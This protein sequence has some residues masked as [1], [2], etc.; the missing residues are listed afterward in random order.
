MSVDVDKRSNSLIVSAPDVVVAEVER[1]VEGLESAASDTERSYRVLPIEN[2][3]P[4]DVR[5]ALE[6]LLN[7]QMKNSRGGAP[8]RPTPNRRAR[9]P[10]TRAPRSTSDASAVAPGLAG[11]SMPAAPARAAGT[12][13]STIRPT[14]GGARVT[15]AG[16][17]R[18]SVRLVG[19]FEEDDGEIVAAGFQ[20]DA[21]AA[22]AAD[23]R[24]GPLGGDVEITVL[25]DIGYLLLIGNDRDLETLAEIVREIEKAAK[26]RELTF[27][28]FPLSH[29]KA[30]ALA[31]LLN[32]LY[33]RLLDSRGQLTRVQAQATVIPLAKPNALLLVAGKDEIGELAELARKFDAPVAARGEYR[34]FRLRHVRAALLVQT[35]ESFYEGRG[36][37]GEMAQEVVVQP[38]D[39]S[40]SI[41][42]YA[43]PNDMAEIAGLVRELDTAQTARVNELR[44]FY[45]RHT[46]ATELA[47]VLEQAIAGRVGGAAAPA[48]G[49]SAARSLPALSF[50]DPDNPDRTIDSGILENVSIT[51]NRR[52]N[53]ILVAAPRQSLGVIESLIRQLDVLPEAVAEIKVFTLVNSDAATLLQTLRTLFVQLRNQQGEV[54]LASSA[55]GDGSNPLIEL[56]FSIDER[57][58]SIL[59]S[60]SREQLEVVEAI[61]LRLDASDIEERRTDVY[62]LKNAPA[63]DVAPALTELLSQ[64][65]QLAG[66]Q[67]G[68]SVQQQLEREIIVVPE[69]IS[70]SLLI[71]ASPRYYDRVTALIEKLDDLPPQVVIQVLLAQVQLDG[72]AELGVELGL[73]DG[74]LFDR[75]NFNST[76]V[77]RTG[78]YFNDGSTPGFNFNTGGPLGNNI[79]TTNPSAI[80][81]QGLSNFAVGRANDT[82]G[83][84]GLVLSASSES[85]SILI[86]ALA[87][88]RRLE[89]LSRPQIMTL[90]NQQASILVGAEVPRITGSNLVQGAGVSQNVEYVPSGIILEVTPKINPDGTIVMQVSP[91]IS[92]LAPANDPDQTVTISPGVTARALEIT[93]ATT[94]VSTQDGQTVVI[95]GLIR[96]ST[97]KEERKVPCLGDVPYLGHLFRYDRLTERRTELLIILT[98][99]VIRSQADAERVKAMEAARMNWCL[100]DVEKVHGDLGLPT[101]VYLGDSASGET[102]GGTPE[103]CLPE[104]L[105]ETV[106]PVDE[107]PI[108]PSPPPPAGSTGAPPQAAAL[109]VASQTARLKTPVVGWELEES[110]RPA[111][112]SARPVQ[113]VPAPPRPAPGLAPLVDAQSEGD[114]RQQA[115]KARAERDAKIYQP[116]M[117]RRRGEMEAWKTKYL[118]W[119]RKESQ[120]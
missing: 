65:Q 22:E 45:L 34:I 39:R 7:R 74:I 14:T 102:D 31:T 68:T 59:A 92:R 53:A 116:L 20:E 117:E 48:T 84:G 85:V 107:G 60:G 37:D 38:D 28:L 36:Q 103:G 24:V 54:A 67:E 81:T 113:T 57:T 86:R 70:N 63:Q 90:D 33:A 26:S 80:G 41:L 105:E 99:H 49:A 97:E 44:I 118:P 91:E 104:A 55:G 21:E 6:I 71:S 64:Q 95:G 79:F 112:A 100:S 96:K 10:R 23:A 32:D 4:T 77:N 12:S 101:E 93:K 120:P 52:A 13:V 78:P 66:V 47:Q 50:R 98:P 75:S 9:T 76:S 94:T 88:E 73:Q 17:Q 40:N 61:I 69:P 111:D 72:D 106:P 15:H 19:G 58:N 42:V 51:P 27:E 43:G 18:G 2:A 110:L 87:R 108:L 25:E 89:V 29:A 115:R 82:L 119:K 11:A 3:S 114:A 35:I 16:P 46:V 56:S 8:S 1:L 5:D 30:S 62:R 83:Y 109:R